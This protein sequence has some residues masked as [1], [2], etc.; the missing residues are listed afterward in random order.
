MAVGGG[1]AFSHLLDQLVG[2]PVFD[3]VNFRLIGA[4]PAAHFPIGRLALGQA[5]AAVGDACR[6]IRFDFA[7]VPE[8]GLIDG[9]FFRAAGHEKL[10]IGCVSLRRLWGYQCLLQRL[11]KTDGA[12]GKG[13]NET[14]PCDQ[15]LVGV[16]K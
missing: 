8:I 4:V 3:A 5:L 2:D 15:A 1:V 9:E 16:V 13:A 12:T 7:A 11:F 10:A 6:S 14:A